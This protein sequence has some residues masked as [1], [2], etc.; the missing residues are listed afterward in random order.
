MGGGREPA[1]LRVA[2]QEKSLLLAIP[3][4]RIGTIEFPI[5]LSPNRIE[6][7]QESLTAPH[8]APQ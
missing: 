2:T 1:T 5:N 3:R 8:S 7:H 6:K 4:N